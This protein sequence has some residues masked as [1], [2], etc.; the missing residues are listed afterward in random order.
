MSSEQVAPAP[1][2]ATGRPAAGTRRLLHLLTPGDHY[3]PSTGSAVPTVV[4]GL[5]AATPA[6][7]P[8]PS[9]LVAAGTYADRY[10]SADAIEYALAAPRR[11]DRYAD[12]ALGRALAVRPGA[13]RPLRTA[14]SGQHAWESSVVLAHN[15][16]Q[17][18]PLVDAARHAG[19][20]YAHNQLLRTYTRREADRVLGPAAA[21]V[22]VSDHLAG[23]LADLLPPS[24][25]PRLV[26]VRNGVD[27]AAFAAPPRPDDGVLRVVYVGRTIP[28][29]GVHVLVEAVRR[30]ARPDV[31]LEVVG[32]AGFAPDAPLT[33]YERSL[34]RLAAPA[35]ARIS[36]RRFV[37][38]DQVAAALA[39][40]DVAAVPSRWPDPCP[41][42]VLEGMASG[43]ALVGSAV[44]GIPEL[45]RD[46]GVLVPPDDADA[47]ADA[48]AGLADDAALLRR[49]QSAGRERA[50][51]R[52]W[53][54][55]H[56]EL[57]SALAQVMS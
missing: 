17:A 10:P 18:V 31:R 21:V 53:R 28:D 46:A 1:V 47:L 19:V 42:T 29:K 38:R 22:A 13:R 43:A 24:V 35:G 37:P 7:A 57:G 51:A 48:L 30:L 50:V 20:L 16:P 41:L 45:V 49:L 9:V 2:A 4:H 23:A 32:G 25:R 44:G 40:A 3:S 56:A 5:S 33:A 15:L 52:D 27:P 54:V 34:R 39:G 6:D 12:L 26:V 14:L 8:R 11:W 55:V 36:F